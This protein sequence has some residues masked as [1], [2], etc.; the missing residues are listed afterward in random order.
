VVWDYE[1]NPWEAI[2]R[3]P[4]FYCL[5]DDVTLNNIMYHYITDVQRGVN[6]PIAMLK[7]MKGRKYKLNPGE[8]IYLERDQWGF[9]PSIIQKTA[10]I[11]WEVEQLKMFRDNVK[12]YFKTD[13]FNVLTEL[14]LAN[15][16][17]ITATHALEVKDEKIT[18]ISPMIESNDDYLRQVD[19]RAMDIE[20]RAGRGPFRPGY[21]EYI[22][23]LIA[24]TCRQEGVPFNG[25]IIPEFTGKLRKEQQTQ[26]KLLPLQRGLEYAKAVK[27]VL[28]EDVLLAMR[29]YSVLDKG[30]NA[31]DY[32]MD[33][34]KTEEEFNEDLAIVN[35]QR[36]Q[37]AQ[38]QLTIEA[39]KAGKGQPILEGGSE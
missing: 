10:N 12:K 33:T 27:D 36:A 1:K 31:V 38:A 20:Y 28:G 35:E 26:Q 8:R 7:E 24:W 11:Q 19:S 29:G 34:F 39:L 32:P 6:P 4:A 5:Y 13:L 9:Q 3:T 17:P 2:S 15:K 37:L 25:N 18:Q 30:L 14:A 22:A 21:M 23:D 16:Q